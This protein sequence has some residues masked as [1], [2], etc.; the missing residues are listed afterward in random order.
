MTTR[1]HHFRIAVTALAPDGVSQGRPT[2]T[3]DHVNHDDLI[4]VAERVRAGAGLD[5][6]MALATAIG[7]KLL[8]ETVLASKHESL[9]DPLRRP[10][11]E[12]TVALKQRVA[13]GIEA[14]QPTAGVDR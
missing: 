8:G 3:F 5:A 12:V 11:R 4:T 10:L 7:L 9:F 1:G 13:A 6:D 2:L 14:G